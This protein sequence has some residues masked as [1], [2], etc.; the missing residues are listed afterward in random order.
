MD[1]FNLNTQEVLKKYEVEKESGLN[2]KQVKR[3]RE[4]YGK[5]KI[6]EKKK[7]SMLSKFLEQFSDFMVIILLIA[8]VVSFV[9]ALMDGSGDYIDSI[10]ILIIVVMNAIIGVI[11]ES[12]AEKA[13]E[14]LKKLSAPKAKVIRNKKE[15]IIDSEDIVPG[16]ILIL[17]TGDFVSADA[18]LIEV[19]ELKTEE[20]SLTG[21][22]LPVEKNV[23]EVSGKNLQ[24]S[25]KSNMVFAG[26]TVTSGRAIG[27][28]TSTG[29][30]TEMG[31]IARMLNEEESPQT[32]LQNRLEQV[33]K[34]LGIG[35]L[36]ICFVIF[37]LGVIEKVAPLEMF[38]ISISLAVAAIPEGLPAVV[39]I[40]LAIGVRRMVSSRAIIRKLPAVETLG[41]ATVICSDKTGTLT[42]NKMT[43]TDI[44]S[45]SG[46]LSV[47]SNEALDI[48]SYASLCNN[49]KLSGSLG[50]FKVSG[51]PT[52]TALVLAAAKAGKNKNVLDDQ[53]K[54]VWEKPFD[55]NRKLMTTVHSLGNGRY[56]VI[57]KGAP[58]VLIKRCTRV[59]TIN[60]SEEL[61]FDRINKIEGYNKEMAENAL[62][63]LAVAIKDVDS[64]DENRAEENLCFCGLIGMIDPPR[65]QAKQAVKEC[66]SAGIKPVMITGDHI[67]T[68]KAIGRELSILHDNEKAMTGAEL[69]ETK[70]EDLEKNIFD[71]SVFARVTPEHKVRIVKAFQSRGAVVAM[72]GDGVNDAPALKAA[73][74]GCAMGIS[75]TDVAKGAA[76][77]I[78]TDD[79]FAT[80]VEAVRQGRGIFEN[81]KKTVHFL[82]S[83]N[84]GEI[85]T[86]LTAFLLKLPS[87]LLAIQLLW[88]NLVTDSLPALALGVE[89]VDE[90]IMTRKPQDPKKSLF[91]GAMGYYIAVEGAFIG[92]IS[93]LAYTIGRV[94]FDAGDIPV[95][96]RTMAFA[97][98]SLSQL[99]HAFNVR[100]ER[101]LFHIGL[102]GNVKMILSF[103]ACLILQVSVISVESLSV[104][105]KTS[106]LNFMQ[107]MIVA[108]LSLSPLVIVEIEKKIVEFKRR[109][110]SK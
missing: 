95:I 18:R 46:K 34:Y 84:I 59:R 96:G 8:S 42:Q 40:V 32:P 77:M 60:G 12:K 43:V 47:S 29:M 13:I 97:V 57:T 58:D 102:F 72:T 14:A 17:D 55:S 106:P 2:S 82:L 75:G 89:P 21:E 74:I 68:A 41:S 65:M 19:H 100:S 108:V 94:Y 6:K 50:N 25:E 5:N 44:R 71:Y 64:I 16:D 107:W 109:L 51:D 86:V 88:V 15:E 66:I 20:S 49:S 39:T 30:N 83:S 38:M 87:P 4:K 3:Q 56:R 63:V 110:R 67:I 61:T 36:I 52:E 103:I 99:V 81:I 10:I 92:A 27:V 54:R 1:S 53:F 91:S 11:Q 93:F 23:N 33:G 35:A 78:M 98:L 79:N 101:S 48:L 62:R 80:I 24:A 104:I 26:S 28:V 69:D 85:I 9:T 105:F 37:V 45:I 76:D 73:N 70:Q 31:K 90:D 22:S 7:K